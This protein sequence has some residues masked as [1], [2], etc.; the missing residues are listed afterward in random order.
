M[1]IRK[2]IICFLLSAFLCRASLAQTDPTSS[3]LPSGLTTYT[4]E[5]LADGIYAFIP[6]ENNSPLVSGNCVVVVGDRSVLVVDSGHSPTMAAQMIAQIKKWTNKPVQYLVNTHWHPDHNSGNGVFREAYPNLE[7]ISTAVT[8]E[9]MTTVLPKKE[10]SAETATKLRNFLAS[11]SQPGKPPFNP[12]VK[13]YYELALPEIEAFLP[14]LKSADHVLPSVVFDNRMSVFLGNREVQ[15]MFLGRG[16][17][18]GDLVVYV[19][20]SKVLITGDLIVYPVPYPYGSFIGEWIETLKKV[21]KIDAVAI[22]PGHGPVMH[23]HEYI[24]REL[25][26]LQLTKSKATEA[27]AAGHTLEQALKEIDLHELRTTFIADH[28]DRTFPFDKGYVPT[29]V[30]RAFREAKEGAL[31]DED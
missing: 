24:D 11:A 29:A 1:A 13:A 8:R 30:K 23:N 27:A 28:P 3:A 9:E 12:V 6:P 21:E 7:I 15:L 14:E 4:T 18:A 26:L 22:V 5:T 31:H 2:V 20:D 19:P 10:I 25:Q 17:T 16:H